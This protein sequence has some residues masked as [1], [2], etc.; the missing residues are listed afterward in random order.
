VSIQLN[1]DIIQRLRRIFVVAN[2]PAYVVDTI[3]DEG[4]LEEAVAGRQASEIASTIEE[5][6]ASPTDSLTEE[7]AMTILALTASLSGREPSVA[8]SL[9]AIRIP[10]LHWWE[11]IREIVI[12]RTRSIAWEVVE[13]PSLLSSEQWRDDPGQVAH[14]PEH[15]VVEAGGT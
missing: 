2:T 6:A 14:S 7:D 8:S 5:I 13:A 10:W 11:E 9:N 4:L 3:M 1:K 15:S 12:R